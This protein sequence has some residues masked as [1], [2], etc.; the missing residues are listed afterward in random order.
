MLV[1]TWGMAASWVTC[2]AVHVRKTEEEMEAVVMDVVIVHAYRALC[3]SGH[4]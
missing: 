1:L 4:T 3:F 2:G